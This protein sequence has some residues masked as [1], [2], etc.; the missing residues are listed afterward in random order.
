[1]AV[2]FNAPSIS[3]TRLSP[4]QELQCNCIVTINPIP[5]WLDQNW[6]NFLLALCQRKTT[7]NGGFDMDNNRNSVRALNRTNSPRPA[8]LINKPNIDKWKGGQ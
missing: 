4:I 1:M 2:N 8:G 3:K 6:P 5:K 7:I